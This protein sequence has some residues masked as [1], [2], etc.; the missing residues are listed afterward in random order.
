MK[1]LWRE[2]R[3]T[4]LTPRD[5]FGRPPPAESWLAPAKRLAFWAFAA[6]LVDTAAVASGL[7]DRPGGL[8]LNVMTLALFPAYILV[9]GSIAALLL[10]GLWKLLGGTGTLQATWRA[11]GAVAFTM[12]LDIVAGELGPVGLAPALWRY[13]LLAF[14]A[15]GIHG[16]SR[17]KAWAV[18]AGLAFLHVLAKSLS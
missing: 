7:S 11:A 3:E 13:A 6:G 9:F 2:A 17:K 1:E 15:Q 14:A 18:S 8:L 12:P 10:H 4:A 5:F 16:L